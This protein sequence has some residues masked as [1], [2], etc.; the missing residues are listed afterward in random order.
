MKIAC[1]YQ[2]GL[3]LPRGGHK[4]VFGSMRDWEKGNEA[5]LLGWLYLQFGPI[6]TKTGAAMNVVE[7]AITVLESRAR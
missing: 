2:G 5:Q 1:E 6:E 3:F 7:R 4:N